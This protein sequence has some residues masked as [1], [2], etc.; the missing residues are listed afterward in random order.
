MDVEVLEKVL[1]KVLAHAEGECTI[2]YQGGEPT[3]IGLDFFKKSI[4]LQNKYNINHVKIYNAIQ[5]NGYY[6]DK[7][8]A[9]FYVDNNFLVGVSLDGGPKIHDHYRLNAKGEGSFH[10]VMDTIALFQKYDVP[11]NILSVVNSKTAPQIERNYEFY[12]KHDLKYLQF[13]ACLDPIGEEPGLRDYSLLPEVYG[14]FLIKLFRL[15][16]QD[17]LQGT[18]PYIRQFE[19]YISMLLGYP[20]ESCDMNGICS[21]QYVVEADGSVY[22]CDFFV[23]DGYRLGSFCEHTVA[24]IDESRDGLGFLE[25]SLQHDKKCDSCRFYPLCRG[26]CTRNR[27]PD[28]PY[29]QYF[30]KAYEMFFEACLPQ[31]LEIAGTLQNRR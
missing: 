9:K 19:N 25:K 15:W 17:L 20:P 6:T 29:H 26:G 18:Q 8:W 28:E 22:P 30:C 1:E 14:E 4:E 21:K 10:R 23:M 2:A 12:K 11:F 13:I 27:Q 24:Q 3:L 31:M 5:T 16:Y 7:E